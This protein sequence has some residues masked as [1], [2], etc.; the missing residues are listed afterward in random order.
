MDYIYKRAELPS[1]YIITKTTQRITFLG[2]SK[3]FP[4][5]LTSQFQILESTYYIAL[6]CL[7]LKSLFFCLSLC[8]PM[9]NNSAPLVAD[10]I[11]F[12]YERRFILFYLTKPS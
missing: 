10:L 11:W 1:V 3:M 12:C 7:L 2:L 5:L 6:C 9:G 4:V 8:I